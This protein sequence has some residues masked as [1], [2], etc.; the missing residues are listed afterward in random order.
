MKVLHINTKHQGGGAARAMQRL[1]KKLVDKGHKS[2]FLIGR[3]HEA[4]P[5]LVEFVGDAVSK[6]RNLWTGF[7]SRFG[8]R[9]EDFWGIHPWAR[10]P[11]LSLPDTEIIQWADLIDLR[12]LFGDYFNMWALP[13]LSASKPVV[14]R[15]PDMWALTGH[16]AYPYDCQRWITG[17]HDCP[18]LT[19]WG[20]RIVEPPPTKWDGTR[21]VWRAK[22]GIYAR[23]QI[24]VIVN[25]DW[26]KKN[27]RE[28][29][30]RDAHSI[31]VISNGVDLDVFRK[32]DKKEVR[33]ELCLP[34]DKIIGLFAAANLNNPRKG[35]RY[36][37]EAVA[38][39]QHK[40]DLTMLITM[41]GLQDIKHEEEQNIQHF[42]YVEDVNMQAKLYAAADLFLCTTLADAQP[43]TALES[44]ACGTPLVAFDVGP[45]ADI[46]GDGVYGWIS[47]ALTPA[48]LA[49]TIE[50]AL[51]YPQQL[52]EIGQR[53][54]KKAELDY[55]LDAQTDQYIALYEN[56]L[57]STS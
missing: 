10:R 44:M 57:S 41:G 53:C 7:L 48:S 49:D 27:V 15:L 23:S 28:S 56:I 34:E 50:E 47:S 19:E 40:Q 13:Q 25:S 2:R 18:L 45:M 5:P 22:K 1:H 51:S 54:R 3:P 26:M 39:V 20:R 6:Q 14:W 52:V 36:A 24:H 9:I 32:Y 37:A 33:R 42:G 55:S 21:W 4:D 16:C 12:N 38:R 17:C 11:T 46:V 8:N 30:L 35:Y 29:I 43:Q 31:N